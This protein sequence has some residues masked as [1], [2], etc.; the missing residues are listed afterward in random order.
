MCDIP[1]EGGLYLAILILLA[2]AGVFTIGGGQNKT[3][4]KSS[5]VQFF[6]K[7]SCKNFTSGL[8]AVI[9]TDFA[10]T[11]LMILGAFVLMITAMV[12]SE[13]QNQAIAMLLRDNSNLSFVESVVMTV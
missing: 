7:N 9:W 3:S 6:V 11:I 8:S 5:N 1:G 2:I 4:N 12:R 10:Q 13:M